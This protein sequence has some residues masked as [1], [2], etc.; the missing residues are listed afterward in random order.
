MPHSVLADL[1][2]IVDACDSDIVTLSGVDVTSYPANRTTRSAVEREFPIIGEA[3]NTISRQTPELAKRSSNARKI[4][5]FR[6]QSATA[7][8]S[9][10]SPA[11]AWPSPASG[12]RDRSWDCGS[13]GDGWRRSSRRPRPNLSKTTSSTRSAHAVTA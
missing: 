4:V 1:R 12:W 10:T 9:P 3:V 5:G 2:D 8:A 6:N 13:R 7:Q 11:H